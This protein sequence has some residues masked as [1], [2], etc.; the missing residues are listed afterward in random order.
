MESRKRFLQTKGGSMHGNVDMNNNRLTNINCIEDKDAVTKE[1][2]D[3]RHFQDTFSLDS[4]KV[5][6]WT[7]NL[8]GDINDVIIKPN[9]CL[10]VKFIVV[11]GKLGKI[12][13]GIDHNKVIEE[14]SNIDITNY[15]SIE[16]RSRRR[17]FEINEC[18]K[19]GNYAGLI[20]VK[21]WSLVVKG[22]SE[23]TG[24]MSIKYSVEARP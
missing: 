5:G 21:Y 13:L 4:I 16:L 17:L 9:T 15:K 11:K 18:I 10:V 23:T 3:K 14:L 2:V 24:L 6:I 12:R 20:G 19:I 8:Q 22:H 1:Y 7:C